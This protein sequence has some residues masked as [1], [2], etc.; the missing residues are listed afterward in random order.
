M[1]RRQATTLGSI[2]FMRAWSWLL[3]GGCACAGVARAA[4]RVARGRMIAV[5]ALIIGH[6]RVNFAAQVSFGDDATRA[7]RRQCRQGV[8]VNGACWAR[9]REYSSVR[10]DDGG[11][12]PDVRHARAWTLAPTVA[13]RPDYGHA[14]ARAASHDRHARRASRRRDQ[15]RA[16]RRLPARDAGPKQRAS[17]RRDAVGGHAVERARPTRQRTGRGCRRHSAREGYAAPTRCARVPGD[18]FAEHALA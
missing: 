3:S 15:I 10:C 4:V 1:S 18:V 9:A 17:D 2:A 6:L 8:S 13:E 12:E 14:I 5:A 11:P 7:R 16:A